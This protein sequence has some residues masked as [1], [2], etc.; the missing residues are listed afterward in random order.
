MTDLALPHRLLMA[1][2]L[3]V[4][5]D[6]A[7]ARAAQLANQWHAEL[8]VVHA[9]SPSVVAQRQRLDDTM[10]SWRRP[11]SWQSL[12][13]HRL[14]ADLASVHVSA[15]AEVVVGSSAEVVLATAQRQSSSLIVLGHAKDDLLDRIQLGSLADAVVRHSTV[16][17]LNVR[18][19][20]HQPYQHVL[21]ATDFSACSA[22]ALRQA[23]GWFPHAQLTVF[24]T[25]IPPGARAVSHAELQGSWGEHAQAEMASFLSSNGLGPASDR[26]ANVLIEKGVPSEVLRDYLSFSDVDLV[27]LGSQG[28]SGLSRILLGSQAE[29]LLHAVDV[30]TLL[31][32]PGE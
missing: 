21:V 4:R 29:A 2:D 32:R 15:H 26:A 5:S 7:L 10:P 18:G 14:R 30:D 25:F 3:S 20:A 23:M 8:T 12:V 1:T 24:H 9:L 13:E 17:V 19:R 31:I 28:R 16:P 22:Q 11:Q 6:R 27:V